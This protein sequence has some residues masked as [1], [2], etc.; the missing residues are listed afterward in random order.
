M[1]GTIGWRSGAAMP[2][3]RMVPF[4]ET[5]CS[6]LPIIASATPPSVACRPWAPEL[7]GSGVVSTPAAL[8]TIS[9]VLKSAPSVPV[10]AILIFFGLAL[11][12]ST[13]S[14]NVLYGLASGT[15]STS[16]TIA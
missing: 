10:L 8:T 6:A 5:A 15:S 14:L 11:A 3:V 9:P 7:N 1:S 4:C 13:R 16:G 2:S 12:Y